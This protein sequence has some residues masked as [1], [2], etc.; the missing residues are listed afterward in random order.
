M[1]DVTP[2]V[3]LA[4]YA[5][6]AISGADPNKTGWQATWYSFRTAL[7]PFVFIFNPQILFIGVATWVDV[8][9]VC[10]SATV[11]SLLFAAA[12]M[13]WFRTKCT[14]FDVG[15]L[16]LA[17]FLFF[18]P[19]Y[20]VDQFYPKY[21]SAGTDRVF[22]V[23]EQLKPNE[24]LVVHTK[25]QSIEGDD[26]IKTV[27][28]PM[29]EGKDGREKIRNAGVTLANLGNE[30]TISDVKFGSRAKKLGVERGF[31]IVELRLPNPNRPADYWIF[32]PAA[33]VAWL[34]WFLQGRRRP[35]VVIK[36]T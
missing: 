9:L 32:I 24:W 7:L 23:A 13:V 35:A 1:A 30:L 34:V 19:D 14:W 28:I 12:T 18:R 6:A 8:V 29:G 3:G 22:D 2:P 5:A 20:V 27:A 36:A 11:A 10:I 25:G 16:L 15:L 26:V 17:T 31:W 21:I 33:L 4:S